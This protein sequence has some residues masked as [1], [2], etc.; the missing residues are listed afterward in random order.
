MH[1]GKTPRGRQWHVVQFPDCST[2]G[3]EAKFNRKLRDQERSAVRRARRLAAMTPDQRAKHEAWRRSHRPGA[4]AARSADRE[5]AR[6]SAETRRMFAV[7]APQRPTDP[8]LVRIRTAL[9]G[10]TAELARLE[11]QACKS[12]DDNKGIFS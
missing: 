12:T 11:T 4:K 2:P 8:E 1:G 7:A 3:G 9:A 5:R 10:A 6:Q